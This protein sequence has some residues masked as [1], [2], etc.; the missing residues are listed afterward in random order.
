VT[1]TNNGGTGRFTTATGTGSQISDVSFPNGL[2]QPGT[3]A[4]TQD[5]TISY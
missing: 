2:G 5:G 1:Y 3:F 4:F